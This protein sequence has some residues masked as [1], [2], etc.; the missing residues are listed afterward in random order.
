M[1]NKPHDDAAAEDYLRMI[2]T[3]DDLL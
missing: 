2:L 3:K 1:H